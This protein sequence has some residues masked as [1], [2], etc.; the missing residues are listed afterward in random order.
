MLFPLPFWVGGKRVLFHSCRSTSSL[1]LD[2]FADSYHVHYRKERQWL[3]DSIIEDLLENSDDL[4]TDGPR[5]PCRGENA[6]SAPWFIL[7]V[8]PQGSGKRYTVEQLVRK[9][10]LAFPALVVVDTEE[11][12]RYLPEYSSYV[13]H[14]PHMVD[15]LTQKEA[16]YIAETLTWAALQQGKTV[17]FDSSLKDAEW[18]V[19]LIKQIRKEYECYQVAMIQVTCSEF[20]VIRRAKERARE[21]GREISEDA[22]LQPL[23]YIRNSIDTV[24]PFVDQSFVIC[25]DESGDPYLKDA[26]WEEFTTTFHHRIPIPRQLP[27]PPRV[28]KHL[29]RIS[30]VNSSEDNHKSDDMNFYG[31]FA[32]IRKTLDYKVPTSSNPALKRSFVVS[33][34]ER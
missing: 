9:N 14:S 26:S 34:I 10:R 7:T 6:A 19:R 27:R 22:I 21:T 28:R 17:V 24:K 30:F 23:C 11:I 5:D 13:E 12:R 16:G 8:G 15:K 31:K 33:S 29:R 18:Y 25:N 20:L 32:Y 1:L 2:G 3:H 4:A